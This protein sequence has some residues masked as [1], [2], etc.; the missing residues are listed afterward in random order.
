MYIAA[1]KAAPILMRFANRR[2]AQAAC[3]E[4]RRLS[5]ARRHHPDVAP[6]E[7]Y[8]LIESKFLRNA[9]VVRIGGYATSC[10]AGF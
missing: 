7:Q 2:H 10:D 6:A 3:E 8:V 5:V 4:D 9:A 1:S